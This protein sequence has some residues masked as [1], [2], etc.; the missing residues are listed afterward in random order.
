VVTDT[1]TILEPEEL[2]IQN[3]IAQY[4]CPGALQGEISV[5]GVTGGIGPYQYSIDGGANFYINN[6]FTSLAPGSYQTVVMDATGCTVNGN[7]NVLHE[8]PQLQILS[9]TQ[10]DITSC[11]DS[12]EGRIT[13]G[14]TGGTGSISYSLNGAP[15]DPSG[16]FQNLPGGPYLVT[17]ID[18]NGCTHDTTVLILAPAPLV[19]TSII[20]TDVTGCNG[21]SNG[22]L[23][24]TAAG[25]TGVIEFSLDDVT[26]QPAGTFNGLSAGDH[27]IWIRDANGCSMTDTATISEPL[28]VAATVIKTDASYG[29]LG[30][31]TISN[32]TGGTPPYEYSINGP[33]G[34]FSNTTLYTDLAPA[35]YPVVVRDNN[36]CTFVQPV[37]I[38]DIPPLNVLVNVSHVSCF[39]ASDGSIEF[40]PQDAEGSVQYSIDDGANFQSDPLFEDLPGNI[41]YQLVAL[42]D[43]GKLFRS[44]V[45]L[46][47]P[48]EIVFSHSVT[49]AHCNA[50]SETGSID[51]SLS[52][53]SGTYTF[54]WSDGGTT[55]DRSSILS[56]IYILE[57]TDGNNC[58]VT[59]TVAVTSEVTVTAFAGLDTTI[60]QGESIQLHGAGSGIPSWNPS[61]YLSDENILDPVAGGMN[62]STTF[63]LTIT[64]TASIYGCYNI[65]SVTINLYPSMG[66]GVTR[67]TFVI[68]GNSLQLEVTGGPFE[69]Y[70]WEPATGLDNTTVPDPVATP[71]VPTVYYV[72][73]LNEHGCEE[74]DSVF[75]D[76]LEDIIAYNV[77]TPNGDGINDY[78]EIKNAERF[79]EMLVE[80]Y[81]RWGD[82]LFST[83]GYD[84]GNQ[85]DG[86]ARGKEVP[87]GTYY[88]ILVPYQGARPIS[89]NVTIIR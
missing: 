50:F 73:A 62:Q 34:P 17:M 30:T 83:V 19:I 2:L 71:V 39:G 43:S 45:V 1:I 60:C 38:L 22:G 29:T 21:D 86:T 25:G 58:M 9:Y 54:L 13:I 33:G 76:V 15:P 89:G 42:D 18:G 12:N 70:R 64:E 72:F 44:T 82:Q 66:L 68:N 46:T 75:I 53:G 35:I 55:E 84:S 6:L 36:G 56:G 69:G 57:I 11:A 31:I 26:Y 20:V 88:Y 27:I 32:V 51:I 78:F 63:V 79:P 40:V 8:P 59:D 65:D 24:V 10:E 4:L 49:P 85:W 80:V 7:L 28:P 81:S 47:E 16:D 5:N 41:T 61:P 52:G 67:D 37:E 77:F 74:V 48:A 23:D 3:E 14:G 87:V